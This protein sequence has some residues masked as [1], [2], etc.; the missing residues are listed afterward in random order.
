MTS[1]PLSPGLARRVAAPEVTA[2]AGASGLAS[3][4]CPWLWGRACTRL[5]V[6][7]GRGGA[8]GRVLGKARVEG[9]PGRPS[10]DHC[11]CPPHI[12]YQGCSYA[13]LTKAPLGDEP[14]P[15][16]CG[17]GEDT[18]G[19]HS[20]E[21]GVYSEA[22]HIRPGPDIC[23]LGPASLLNP[24]PALTHLPFENMAL[25]LISSVCVTISRVP[26]LRTFPWLR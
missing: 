20:R 24:K 13:A 4:R 9:T 8:G 18:R 6:G 7:L 11:G 25:C 26:L 21:R 23:L 10:G 19:S 1:P 14:W 17:T 3:C 12:F 15:C 16:P 2:S 5:Q 22:A